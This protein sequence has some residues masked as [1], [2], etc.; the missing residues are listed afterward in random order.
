MSWKV[1]AVL[2]VVLF[3]QLAG[4]ELSLRSQFA[5]YV[6]KYN[7]SYASSVET[8]YRM[9]IFHENVKRIADL[10]AKYNPKTTFAINKF[11]DLSKNEFKAKYLG[12]KVLPRDPS[13]PVAPLYEQ[14][15]LQ[16]IPDSFDW[17][18]KGAVTPVKDQ[19]QCGSCWSFSTTG[20]IEGQW[21]LAGHPIVGL[22]EHNLVDCDHDCSQ[23]EGQQVCDAGCD[24]GLMQNAYDYVM[25]SGGIDTEA[26]YQ[27]QGV[28]GQ[29]A[30][31]KANIGATIKNWTFISQDEGQMAAYLVAN[32]PLSIAADAEEWQFYYEGVFYL[33]DCGT[34]LD[35]GILI[36]GYG[37]ETDI[38]DQ[39]MPYWIIKNSWGADWGEN[40]YIRIERGDGECG[41]NLYVSSAIV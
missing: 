8:T 18:T 33:P 36:V 9:G 32:G 30:F 11:A 26:S 5:Q 39:N 12:T 24:G 34:D 35:H 23:W 22:S 40:G 16:G 2:A 31:N 17:R 3:V 25:Q 1:C 20:N 19:G 10:N 21:F 37:S 15:V 6:R 13:W 14:K 28:D 29:C 27:Y 41:I 38:F 4:C 7:K